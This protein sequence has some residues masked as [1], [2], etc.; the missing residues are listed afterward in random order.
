MQEHYCSFSFFLSSIVHVYPDNICE[1]TSSKFLHERFSFKMWGEEIIFFYEILL[2]VQPNDYSYKKKLLSLK[3]S[4]LGRGHQKTVLGVFPRIL[5]NDHQTLENFKVGQ[6]KFHYLFFVLSIHDWSI[7]T[8]CAIA[9]KM[10]GVYFISVAVMKIFLVDFSAI[11][12]EF[13]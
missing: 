13:C 6:I 12:L 1:L 9:Y 3:A 5:T 11:S 2:Q 8:Y 7:I 10:E 4:E